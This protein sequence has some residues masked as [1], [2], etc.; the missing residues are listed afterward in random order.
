MFHLLAFLCLRACGPVSVSVSVVGCGAQG[1]SE[2]RARA[3]ACVRS[4]LRGGQVL[5]VLSL[6]LK[7]SLCV[8]VCVCVCVCGG[9][10]LCVLS[11]VYP[12]SNVGQLV[13][14][15]SKKN[16]AS[17]PSPSYPRSI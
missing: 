16:Q 14:V 4:G 3:R 15:P 1:L 11:I 6:G 9:Q 13:N 12:A 2:W 8:C 10:V 5:C 7:T 17:A